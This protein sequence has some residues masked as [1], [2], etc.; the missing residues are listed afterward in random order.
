[1]A[2]DC[3]GTQYLG[4]ARW[5]G[6]RNL[7][8]IATRVD[9]WIHRGDDF[10]RRAENFAVILRDARFVESEADARDAGAVDDWL[11]APRSV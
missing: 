3:C 2:T 5:R 8:S 6:A 4:V 9:R 11:H 1:M 7:G 10:F